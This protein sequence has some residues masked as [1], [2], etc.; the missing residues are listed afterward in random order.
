MD[1]YQQ[2]SHRVDCPG[3]G[4]HTHTHERT[5]GERRGEEGVLTENTKRFKLLSM[6]V[7]LKRAR[8]ELVKIGIIATSISRVGDGYTCPSLNKKFKQLFFLLPLFCISFV[9]E[10]ANTTTPTAQGVFRRTQPR[11]RRAS[12][13]IASGFLS[14][15]MVPLNLW[16]L[17]FGFSHLMATSQPSKRRQ[18]MS[19]TPPQRTTLSEHREEA[20]HSH[21]PSRR[22]NV[23]GSLME[24]VS[25][26]ERR[27]FKFVSLQYQREKTSAMTFL[28]TS[29]QTLEQHGSFSLTHRGLPSQ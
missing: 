27:T 16:R 20:A 9:S 28:C 12:L 22:D 25:G 15:Y 11:R 6:C 21:S 2:R 17:L 23:A 14:R 4:T 7:L 19:P 26:S 13:S 1:K 29:A 18:A 5:Q 3:R 10:P 8:P 24:K